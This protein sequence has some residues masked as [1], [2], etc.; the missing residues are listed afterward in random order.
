MFT[1]TLNFA[2]DHP[3]LRPKPVEERL[4]EQKERTD[5]AIQPETRL[6]KLTA[7]AA[8]PKMVWGELLV[9]S[10][11]LAVAVSATMVSVQE[12][13]RLMRSNAIEHVAARALYG[14]K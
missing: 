12:L 8:Q 5:G 11:F 9:L 2:P 14:S 7:K 6:W 1:T 3:L 13:S 10:V 4:T